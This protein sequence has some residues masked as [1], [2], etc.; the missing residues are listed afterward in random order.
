[1]PTL[2]S[3]IFTLITVGGIAEAK[4]DKA[5]ADH[6]KS[7]TISPLKALWPALV[8]EYEME[9]K[10]NQGLALGLAVGQY[11]NFLFRLL[12][13]TASSAGADIKWQRQSVNAA[14]NWYFNDFNRGWYG[15]A[16]T[17]YDRNVLVAEAAGESASTDPYSTLTVGP[18]IGLKVASEG[19]FTFSW[20]IGMGYRTTFGT[21]SEDEGALPWAGLGSLNMGWSF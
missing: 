5:I 19:G 6:T 13:G 8:A 12:Q 18:H 9:I 11:N 3:S 17:K 10:E 4:E 20:N 21:T 16:A 14:Y 15:G 7:V 1:M 2:F